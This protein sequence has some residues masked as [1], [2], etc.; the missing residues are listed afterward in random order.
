MNEHMSR[1]T[2]I[3]CV[4]VVAALMLVPLSG[5]RYLIDLSTEIIIYMLFALSLN[6]IIGFSGN[7]SF[8]H[9]AYFSIGGYT[10]VILLTTYHW[11]VVLALPAAVIMAGLVAAFVG[12]F[13]VKL[14]DIYFAMLTLAFSMFVWGVVF[15]WRSVTGGDDGFV[16][17]AIPAWL[18]SRA[19]F[20]YF[21]LVIITVSIA[22][23]WVICHS[24]FG[25]TLIAVRENRV[26]A[27]FVGVD[28]RRMR[29]TAFVVAGTFA[30]IAGALFGMYNR[31]MYTES[32]FWPESAQV[33]IMT[34]L[35]GMYSFFGPAI[36]AAVL[37]LL[38][39]FTNQFTEYWPTVLG[40]T[41]LA[42]LL[43]LP[44]GI[45]GLAQKIR[46]K[47]SASA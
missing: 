25:R 42:I 40:I 27:G 10:C 18:D 14:N 8:G 12:Y 37:Y 1:G 46:R 39:V 43:F 28:T 38:D 33:L 24:A 16:G 19:A 4:V 47:T 44:E 17:V 2:A 31:G 34:L 35:G 13:C 30:G 22:V 23:L 5:S 6:V 26:R 7:V 21:A 15:K 32:A 3:A 36:G 45:V 41:L 9:A 20:F 11:P 29:W